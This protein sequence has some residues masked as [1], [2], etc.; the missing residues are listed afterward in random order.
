MGIGDDANGGRRAVGRT[1][2]ERW[3]WNHV[4]LVRD[5]KTARVYLNGD[6]DPEIDREIVSGSSA[7]PDEV[8]FG[9]RSDNESNWEGRLDE[10]AIFDRA[11][12]VDEIQAIHSLDGGRCNQVWRPSRRSEVAFV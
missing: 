10:I 1:A 9:G 4:A 3:A 5:G 12:S 7:N 2:I 6:P 8:F 11:L